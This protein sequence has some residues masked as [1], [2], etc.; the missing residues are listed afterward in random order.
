MKRPNAGEGVEQQEPSSL[1]VGMQNSATTLEDS[2]WFLTNLNI[3]LPY[4]PAITLL[5][6]YPMELKT[7]IHTN[8][9]HMDVHSN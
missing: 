8:N 6:I 9:L 7:Y 3:L 4:N 5:G 1:L 2:L